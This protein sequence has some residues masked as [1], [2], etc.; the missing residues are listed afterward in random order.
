MVTKNGVRYHE[1]PCTKEQEA[2]LDAA[3]L[4]LPAQPVTIKQQTN[5]KQQ[6]KLTPS[7]QRPRGGRG[8]G[9]A[10]D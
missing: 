5:N 9:H 4:L 6:A 2:A 7:R 1:P 8:V 3:R 10:F